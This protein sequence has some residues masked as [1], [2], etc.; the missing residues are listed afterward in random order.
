[1]AVTL[2]SQCQKL[3]VIEVEFVGVARS[4]HLVVTAFDLE[5]MQCLKTLQ[6]RRGGRAAQS[7][8]GRKRVEEAK[9]AGRDSA[10][11]PTDRLL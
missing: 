11:L 7:A 5:K 6:R 10:P 9:L 8:R 2:I 4:Q 3:R 1:V